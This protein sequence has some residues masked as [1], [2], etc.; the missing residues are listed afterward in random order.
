[1][2]AATPPPCLISDVA[3]TTGWGEP[4]RTVPRTI[5]S[6][7]STRFSTGTVIAEGSG[8]AVSAAICAGERIWAPATHAPTESSSAATSPTATVRLLRA[9]FIYLYRPKPVSCRAA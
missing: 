1:M 9:A 2:S 7:E 5:T 3:S 6:L 8:G 4:Y